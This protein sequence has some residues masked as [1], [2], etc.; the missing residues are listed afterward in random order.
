MRGRCLKKLSWVATSRRLVL[1]HYLCN[2]CFHSLHWYH[3]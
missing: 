3:E 2:I 1:C